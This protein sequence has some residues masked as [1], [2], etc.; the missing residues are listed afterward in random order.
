MSGQ[1]SLEVRDFDA[2]YCGDYRH[3]H[4]NGTGKCKLGSL[5]TPTRCLKFRLHKEAAEVPASYRRT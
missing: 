2:C 5:C 1:Q 4:E 3:Q